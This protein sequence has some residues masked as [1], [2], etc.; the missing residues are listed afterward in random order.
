M[1]VVKT[2]AISIAA[3][4]GELGGTYCY[5]R[6]FKEKGPGWLPSPSCSTG[7]TCSPGTRP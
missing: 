3:A 7:A 6:W 1:D 4:V 5:W 2:F